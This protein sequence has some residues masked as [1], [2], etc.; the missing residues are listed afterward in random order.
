MAVTLSS[1]SDALIFRIGSDRST[2]HTLHLVLQGPTQSA[3]TSV[4]TPTFAP[5]A[6]PEP[7]SEPKPTATPVP[8]PEPTPVPTPAP[9]VV[10][11]DDTVF[12]DTSKTKLNGAIGAY[13]WSDVSFYEQLGSISWVAKAPVKSS[14]RVVWQ[15]TSD[16]SPDVTFSA[17]LAAERTASGTKTFQPDYGEY[18]LAVTSTCPSWSSTLAAKAPP[19]YWNPWRYNFTP[20]SVIYNPPSDFCSYFDCIASFW[21]NTRGYVMQ[22]RDLMFSHSGG[23]S[24]SCSWHGGNKR[25]LYRH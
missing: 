17:K 2:A 10:T 18:Q 20:G 19:P 14:C 23:R 7:S 5:S 9:V 12:V 6:S 24:G 21:N 13:I 3:P 22:C 4:E 15:L 8:T 11:V 16:S 25:A 1:G